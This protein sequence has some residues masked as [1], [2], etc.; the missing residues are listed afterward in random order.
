MSR[1]PSIFHSFAHLA[2]P[3]DQRKALDRIHRHLLPGG[4]FICTLTNPVLRHKFVDGQ[5]HLFREYLLPNDQ[6]TLL[7]NCDLTSF[8]KAWCY[9][10]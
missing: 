8:G 2:S 10:T 6:G 9:G 7:L 4:T 1:Q 5:L 3:E